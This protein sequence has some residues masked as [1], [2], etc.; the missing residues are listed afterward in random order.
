MSDPYK[1]AVAIALTSNHSAVLGAM[2]KHLLGLDGQ[3]KDIQK[4]FASW[5]APL[6]GVAAVLGG[7]AIAR[8]LEALVKHGGAVNHELELMKTAGMGVVETQE[9][10]AQAV[11][12]SGNVLT[13]T[14]SENLRHI[15]ELRY[16]FGETTTAIA[17]LDEI[18]KA[19]S[20]LNNVKGG[21]TDQV[22]ELVKSLEM[23]GETYDPK[24]FSSY[25]DT[26]TKVVEATRGRVTPADFMSTFKYGRTATL[27]WSE[28]FVGGALPRL[29]QS[30]KANGGSGGAGGPGNALMSAFA[31]IV[32]GQMPKNAAEEFDRMGLAPGGVE[33]IKGSSQS[34]IPG[35]IAGRDLF[36][37]NPYE[38]VQ[39]I[40]MPALTAHGITSQ[41]DIIAEISKLLPVRTASQIVSEMALQGR[42]HEGA[43]SPFEK[44]IRLQ[45]QPMG[46][47]AYG[48]LIKNDY[49]MVLE[50]FNK[51]WVNLPE[52][53]GSPLMAPG[54]P[55]ISAM[56]GMAQAMGSLAHVAGSN[57]DAI[58]SAI[59]IM[60][61]FG[62]A[63]LAVGEFA[64]KLSGLS[65]VF[66]AF[67]AIPWGAIG[68][69]LDSVKSA[70]MRLIDF[71]GAIPGM[72]GDKLKGMFS[73]P[74]NVPGGDPMGLKSPTSFHPGTGTTIKVAPT[75]INFAIDGRT[76]GQAVSEQLEFLAEH[77]TG[78]PAANGLTHFPRADGGM[79][80]T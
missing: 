77:A 63:G 78:A 37:S 75:T 27:G 26:M 65:A 31:K 29:I 22:W 56:A 52:S 71:L 53:L 58:K 73:N 3:I 12:T 60:Q 57:M 69:G 24:S 62:S 6:L 5:K 16:A 61:T 17:H 38:W 80:G 55:V 48:E 28:E 45:G 33:H 30:M 72:V 39:K 66:Q 43:N 23:K 46:T 9:A 15:S 64:F 25:V 76:L 36:M 59:G 21:G 2:S 8:G 51:Q 4:S 1:V 14:M 32:Q 13:T 7:V 20:V 42:F 49:P 19:N 79:I 50:A 41:N 74:G 35:G 68:S 44:D 47:A 11:K 54:G 10:I 70:I 67:G 18:A 34:Q 40:L